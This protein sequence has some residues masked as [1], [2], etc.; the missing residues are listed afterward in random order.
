MSLLFQINF[1]EGDKWTA[2]HLP[3]LISADGMGYIFQCEK[4][5]EKLAFHWDA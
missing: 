2:A 1:N 3:A 5:P 4:H